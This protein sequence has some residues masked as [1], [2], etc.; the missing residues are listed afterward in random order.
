MTVEERETI[1]RAF[2]REVRE[3]SWALREPFES[4][5]LTEGHHIAWVTT[6]YGGRTD[7]LS[8]IH[9][10][11]SVESNET[12]CQ[13]E[14]PAPVQWLEVTPAWLATQ[15]LCGHCARIFHARLMV[16]HAAA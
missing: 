14:I 4:T 2:E 11:G 13:E 12:L 1:W 16:E 6:G 7:G 15:P 10:V 9:R 8:P 3:Q 5:P